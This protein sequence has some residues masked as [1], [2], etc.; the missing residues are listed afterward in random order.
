MVQV[1]TSMEGTAAAYFKDFPFTVASKTGTPETGLESQGSSSNGLFIAYAP[2]ENPQIAVAVVV[3][4][5]VWGSYT[6]P[7]AKDVLEEYFGLNRDKYNDDQISVEE[8]KF[9]R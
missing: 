5:G 2:A 1:S 7:I 9:T 4:H 6:V 3:E 8:V